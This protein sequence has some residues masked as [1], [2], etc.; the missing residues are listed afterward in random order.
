MP[1]SD[2]SAERHLIATLRSKPEHRAQVQE[3]LVQLVDPVR[4]ESG[5]LYYN[6]FQQAEDPDAFLVV[7]GWV[8]DAAVAAHPTDPHVP[9]VVE[10]VMPLLAALRP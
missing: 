9:R 5:C 7:A 2:K 10:K 8:D 4:S 3:L 1:P 6:I